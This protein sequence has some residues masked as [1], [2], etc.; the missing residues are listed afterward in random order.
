MAIRFDL[1]K[2]EVLDQPVAL[3]DNVIQAFSM[4]GGYHSRAG[5]SGISDTGSLIYAECGIPPDPKN[6]L[7]WVDQS[8]QEQPATTLQFAFHMPRLSPDGKRIAYITTGLEQQVWIYDLTKGTNSRLTREGRACWPIW[9]PDGTRVLFT[10]HKS[11]ATNLF[12][13]PYDGSSAMERLTSSENNHWPASW[14]PGG[15][16]LI[17]VQTPPGAGRLISTLDVRTGRVTPL[18]QL[19]PG[20]NP[21]LSPD[22]HW[23]AYDSN[24]SK[25]DEV[26]VRPFPGLDRKYQVSNQGGTQPLWARNGKQLFYRRQDQVW[27]VTVRTDRKFTT[28]EPRLL[29]E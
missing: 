26:Y 23:I 1:A 14:S 19:Q 29:F 12:W 8:G 24:E 27:A 16:I 10:W 18:P 9:T 6:S 3:V 11:L 13:Q 22:G 4:A 15:Q 7:V 5:Q 21:D 28:S 25:R 17:F 2:L 20:T